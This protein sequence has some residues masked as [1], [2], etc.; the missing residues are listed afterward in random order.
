MDIPIFVRTKLFLINTTSFMSD[1][2]DF[3]LIGN[4]AKIALNRPKV[5]NSFNREMALALQARLEECKNNP[6]IRAVYLT[7]N[8]KA[9]CAGQDLGEVVGEN[10]PDLTKILNEHLNPIVRLIRNLDKPVICAVNGV[11]AGAGANMALACDITFAAERVSFIQAFSKIGL[12]PDMS[13]TYNLPR[14]IGMQR[15][16]A[17]MMTGDKLS[18][19]E[20]EKIGMIYKAVPNE[21]LENVAFALAEKLSKMPTAALGMTKRALNAS[22]SNSLEEQLKVEDKYQTAASQTEDYA[23][24]VA[25]FLE[26]RKPVFKG[27]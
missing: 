21:E 26:K 8:G 18:A 12:I 27:K 22:L 17:L 16:T 23:E 20:A 2:I 11:A 13:G 6:E 9:F 19:S 24:G 25:A 3:T 15:A 14:L 7:G 5:Y 4:V 1:T 10:A